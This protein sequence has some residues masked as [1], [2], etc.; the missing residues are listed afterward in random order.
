[1]LRERLT[2]AERRCDDAVARAAD[3]E[4]AAVGYADANNRARQVLDGVPFDATL[5]QWRQ[6]G[7]ELRRVLYGWV[8][9]GG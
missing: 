5:D 2:V 1:M 3:A 7:D 8:S 4:R 6:A 9:D